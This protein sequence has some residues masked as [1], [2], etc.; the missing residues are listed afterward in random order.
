MRNATPLEMLIINNQERS[1]PW[2]FITVFCFHK[3]AEI[4]IKIDLTRCLCSTLSIL[5]VRGFAIW[6]SP[7]AN[8]RAYKYGLP[9]L[10]TTHIAVK[11]QP[12]SIPPTCHQETI[13][14]KKQSLCIVAL[15]SH[16]KYIVFLR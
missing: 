13:A 9:R 16:A 11:K 14:N 5:S 1:Y 2:V 10:D 7:A 4:T 15:H 8:S 6:S 3:R 12:V